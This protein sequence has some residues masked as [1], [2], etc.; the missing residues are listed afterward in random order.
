MEKLPAIDQV[1]EKRTNDTVDS[2]SA[3]KEEEG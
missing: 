3:A 1:L 2:D